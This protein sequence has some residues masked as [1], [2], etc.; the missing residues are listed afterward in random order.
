M[1]TLKMRWA[2]MR[3]F[4]CLAALR[5]RADRRGAVAVEFSLV[6]IP[7]IALLLAIF[8]TMLVLFTGQV[9][10]TG[11]QDSA[12]MIMTGNAQSM[13]AANFATGP[14]GVCSRVTALF[15]CAAAYN[16]GTLQIDIRTPS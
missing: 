13:T 12:R 4:A 14:S 5:F 15:N 7:F 2:C 8:Q 10:D 16:A 11:L 6:A 9:L 3:K 1:K